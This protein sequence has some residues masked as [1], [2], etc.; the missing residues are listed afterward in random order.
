MPYVGAIDNNI[1]L[2][3]DCR[4]R[5]YKQVNAFVAAVPQK[6]MLAGGTPLISAQHFFDPELMRIRVPVVI[7][8]EGRSETVFIGIQVNSRVPR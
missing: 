4:R 6:Y 1:V 8:R 2:A 3:R 5:G 7:F